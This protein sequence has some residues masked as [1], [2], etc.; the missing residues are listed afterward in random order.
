MID[1]PALYEFTYEEDRA[2][3]RNLPQTSTFC[4]ESVW[5]GKSHWYI[6]QP[7]IDSL[8]EQ[9]VDLRT[10]FQLAFKKPM[11]ETLLE[12]Q[13]HHYKI[14]EFLGDSP[15]LGDLTDNP[16]RF[17]YD[18]DFT[19]MLTQKLA[20]RTLPKVQG[21]PTSTEYYQSYDP[22]TGVYDNIIARVDFDL[23]Y[24]VLGFITKKEALL[25]FY[26]SDG[27][28][29]HTRFK[30][31]GRSYDAIYD[32]EYRIKEGVLRRQSI[33]DNLQLP[34]LGVLQAVFPDTPMTA[35]V[36]LGRDFLDRYEREFDLFIKASKKDIIEMITSAPDTWLEAP[37]PPAG[38]GVTVRQ[39]LIFELSISY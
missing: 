6:K 32:A 12:K 39:Y 35:V 13:K 3:R 27:S 20:K 17:P 24:D 23:T 9:N 36:Q 18:I 4:Y 16:W 38:P 34:I 37:F 30:D 29:D 33:V 11:S 10:A 7:K 21:K 25:K 19:F 2:I 14:Y 8:I 31:I 26:K 5:G 1:I 22:V 28:V 15:N